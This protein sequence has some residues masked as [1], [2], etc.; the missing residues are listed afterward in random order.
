MRPSPSRTAPGVCA[1]ESTSATNQTSSPTYSVLKLSQATAWRRGSLQSRTNGRVAACSHGHGQP[2][3]ETVPRAPGGGAGGSGAHP[4]GWHMPA[5]RST[6]PPPAPWPWTRS[7]WGLLFAS[8]GW[9]RSR[10][11]DDNRRS[12]IV[13]PCAVSQM[14]T[15]TR[16]RAGA[17]RAPRGPLGASDLLRER[18]LRDNNTSKERILHARIY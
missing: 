9:A 12:L 3:A 10:A 13:D 5:A 4:G 16:G 1:S 8:G 17:Q 15:P 11:E 2:S 7:A 18:A 6:C 14:F